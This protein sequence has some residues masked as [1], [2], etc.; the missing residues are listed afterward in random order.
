MVAALGLALVCATAALADS[1]PLEGKFYLSPLG[2]YYGTPEDLGY[3]DSEVGVGGA[4]GWSF[5]Q[6]WAGELTY[7]K[8]SAGLQGSGRSDDIESIWANILY[9][10]P[11]EQS[12]QPYVTFGGG[13][14]KY[15][16]GPASTS[17]MINEFNAGVGAFYDLSDRLSMRGDVR[18]IYL[19]GDDEDV[20]PFA[21]V[22]FAYMLGKI[23]P[24]VAPDAD[25]DGVPDLTD[26][27]P[28]TPPGRRVDANGCELDG[29]GDGVVDGADACPNTPKGVAVDSRGCPRDS[30]GD[31]VTDDLD[32]CPNTPAGT[33]V[34]AKGCPVVVKE[35]VRFDLTVE[36]AYDAAV[37]NDLSF[38]ELR[39]AMQFLREHPNTKAVI[40]G[41]TDSRGTDSYNMGLS[42]RRAAAVVD[43]LTRSGIEAS[44]LTSVGYGE[45]RPIAS[46]DTD[47]GRQRNRR[48]SIVVSEN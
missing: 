31:G 16:R 30:D 14:G 24:K 7:W 6:D 5:R 47:E 32:Q 17:E 15:D 10:I 48:V 12:W 20:R 38:R 43:V 19:H 23:E 44:R 3:S 11:T 4:F 34:D 29:D 33:K 21:S 2:A 41:H 42:Q 28:G 13:K 25:G 26:Q 40:E 22:G 27:C 39:R 35:P 9:L 37:I 36:F 1:G 45:S 46:N 8:Y 18:G